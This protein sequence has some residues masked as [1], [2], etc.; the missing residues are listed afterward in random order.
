MRSMCVRGCGVVA[1]L[2]VL[3]ACGDDDGGP[4]VDAGTGGTGAT[5]GTAG[6][7][8]SGGG[9]TSGGGSGGNGGSGG[10]PLDAAIEDAGLTDAGQGADASDASD[11]MVAPT[12]DNGT[13]CTTDQQCISG[14]CED[15][16][17]CD[18]ACE[19][20]CHSCAA[21]D[22]DDH[23]GVCAPVL[24][25]NDP[26]SDCDDDAACGTGQCDGAGTC[27]LLG[28]EEVC[29]PADGPCDVADN[30]TGTE[31]T[32]PDDAFVGPSVVAN[33]APYFCS[34]TAPSCA[35]TCSDH[36]DCASG[37]VCASNACVT[38]RRIFVTSSVHTGNL[39]GLAGADAICGQLASTA[40]LSG[41][42]RAWLSDQYT[43]AQQRL[44]HFSGPYYRKDGETVIPVANN[45]ADLT[46]GQYY[47]L[48]TDENGVVRGYAN[49][50]TN[51]A[52][53]GIKLNQHCQSW[54]SAL[55]TESGRVGN[56]SAGN[57][58]WTDSTTQACNTQGRLYC[59]ETVPS[60]S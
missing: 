54:T 23:D 19:G 28:T 52:G 12:L 58:D 57:S 13:A 35:T 34:A 40:G 25:G 32:C 26:D 60:S 44:D 42:F 51:T 31:A 29:R 11:A 8:G 45:W 56:S 5:A 14:F 18:T 27:E 21:V 50:W 55:S 37:T 46:D 53:N 9:G 15:D 1:A 41:T 4:N 22:T 20:M 36:P 59:V 43:S 48:A 24:A 10:E 38:A 39:G 2:L 6:D 47:A 7:G 30:C 33:C 17:C 3:A 16:V 49:V